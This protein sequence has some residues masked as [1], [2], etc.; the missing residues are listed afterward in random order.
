[1]ETCQKP[2]RPVSGGF[3][4]F[5]DNPSWTDHTVFY[6]SFL[7]LGFLPR[8]S[9]NKGCLFGVLKSDGD[10]QCGQR[11]RTQYDYHQ[12]HRKDII[13]ISTCSSVRERNDTIFKTLLFTQQFHEFPQSLYH[14]N[15][16]VRKSR[17]R[18]GQPSKGHPCRI[19]ILFS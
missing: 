8:F 13:H 2:P 14:W 7:Q 3:Q 19:L 9:Y 15:H 16:T 18:L 4:R 12:V 1:M 11:V 5:P 10:Y 6:I 17:N